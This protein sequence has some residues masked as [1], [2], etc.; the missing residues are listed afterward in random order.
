MK[1]A[2]D[3]GRLFKN[4]VV[5]T[6]SG[7]DDGIF[8]GIQTAYTRSIEDRSAQPKPI[9]WTFA[10]KS[11]KTKLA[12]AA[13]VVIVGAVMMSLWQST[14]P[15]IALADVLTR[16][17]QISA[18]TY[19][20]STTHASQDDG[21]KSIARE[22]H[23]TALISQEHGMKTSMETLDANSGQSTRQEMYLLPKK[24]T[25]VMILHD[26]KKYMRMEF[27]NTLVERK[28][29]EINDPR[30]MLKQLLKCDHKSLGQST[31]D[32][33]M[34]E[35]FQTRDPNWLGEA[36]GQVDV[37]IWVDVKTWLPVRLEVSTIEDAVHRYH[38]VDS[39]QWNVSVDTDEFEPHIPD[40]Y[41]SMA[42]G[43]IKIPAINEETVI[44]GLRLY[45][46]LCD[47]Y[48]EDLGLV[49]IMS[50][51]QGT[52]EAKA[53]REEGRDINDEQIREAMDMV[54]PIFGLA[55]FHKTLVEE[56]KD[57]A[58]Y[59]RITTLEDIDQVLMRWK[60]SD[61][62]YRVIFGDLHAETVTADVLTELETAPP[63]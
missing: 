52:P 58:Y 27:D 5:T 17:E 22:T 42:G 7:L 3:I 30:A 26:V 23:A 24:K 44:R 63:R 2:E 31:I 6:N 32:G 46:K 60:I 37:K 15:G 38:V 61:N 10:M 36:F 51:V 49:T 12:I 4:A 35:G 25:V 57:P 20:I 11:P 13:I 39:F 53:L 28:L 21:D 54:M 59:G 8:R 19:Q 34:V 1:S 62:E 48:P 40:G 9:I 43:P 41:E 50:R 45:A 33:A 55:Q 29:K 18:Y 47:R 14:G 56:K 16:I